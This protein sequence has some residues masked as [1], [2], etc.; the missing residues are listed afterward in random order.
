MRIAGRLVGARALPLGVMPSVLSGAAPGNVIV[1]GSGY[2]TIPRMARTGIVL[3]L[4]AA[5]LAS[6]WC[7]LGVRYILP[8]I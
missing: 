4:L 7:A 6:A 8:A 3:D 1:F 5:L 2:V